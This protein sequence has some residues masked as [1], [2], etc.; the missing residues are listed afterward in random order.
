MLENPMTI[1]AEVP[2]LREDWTCPHCGA[3][4]QRD[5][6][7]DGDVTY[8]NEDYTVPESDLKGYGCCWACALLWDTEEDRRRYIRERNLSSEV[9]SFW[10]GTIDGSEVV[11]NYL[12]NLLADGAADTMDGVLMTFMRGPRADDYRRWLLKEACT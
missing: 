7:S 12:Y 4:W 8:S 5:I 2:E 6:D 3:H 10:L 11:K 9:M 1:G